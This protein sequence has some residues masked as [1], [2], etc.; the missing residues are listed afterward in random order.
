MET[1]T[2]TENLNLPFYSP[3]AQKSGRAQNKARSPMWVVVV[4]LNEPSSVV[5]Q[6]VQEAGIET[7]MLGLEHRYSNKECGH[8]KQQFHGCAIWWSVSSFLVSIL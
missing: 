2:D 7:L 6:G 3:N 4:Q 5:F 8:S 1:Q